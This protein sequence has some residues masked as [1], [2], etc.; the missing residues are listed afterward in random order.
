MSCDHIYKSLNELGN[1]RITGAVSGR[2]TYLVRGR[3]S[4][5]KKTKDANK[6]G[7]KILDEDGFYELFETEG[8]KEIPAPVA[9]TPKAAKGKG[10]AAAATVASSSTK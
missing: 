5:E 1:R 10:K 6:H 9:E 3:D 2:T 4:G 7:T 8:G